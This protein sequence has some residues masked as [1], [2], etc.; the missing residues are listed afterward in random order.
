M[1]QKNRQK[2]ALSCLVFKQLGHCTDRASPDLFHSQE[3]RILLWRVSSPETSDFVLSSDIHQIF[4]A[5]SEVS[6]TRIAQIRPNTTQ[7]LDCARI[8]WLQSLDFQYVVLHAFFNASFQMLRILLSHHS[9]WRGCKLH[10]WDTRWQ[11]G[12]FDRM[13]LLTNAMFSPS[14]HKQ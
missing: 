13:F 14:S 11:Q 12:H 5:N 1:G 6:F 2:V 8:T 7:P 3:S 9:N 4:S 10:Q